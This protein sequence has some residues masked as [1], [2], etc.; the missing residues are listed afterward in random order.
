MKDITPKEA[1]SG[2]RPS[3]KHFMIF[4]SICHRHIPDERKRKLDDKSEALILIGYHPTGAYKLYDPV[5]KKVL[6][7]RD[8]VV[9]ESAT[10]DWNKPKPTSVQLQ[11]ECSDQVELLGQV[12]STQQQQRRS[13]RMRFHLSRLTDFKVFCS[14]SFVGEDEHVHMALLADVEP[15]VWQQAVQQDERKSAVL[16]ELNAIERNSTWELVEPPKTKKPI[17]VKWVFKLKRK[18]DGT[19]AKHKARLVARGF[20]QKEGVNYSKVYAPVARMETIRL[21]ITIASS[22]GWPMFQLHV[23]SA[24]LNGVLEEEVYVQQPPGFEMKGNEQQVAK[25]GIVW[26]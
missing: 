8:V 3:V 20:L 9:D 10:W 25:E 1:W 18:P 7:S 6:I 5:Q 26:P 22:K 19:I 2:C 21:A 17:D 4:G 24:F 11:L 15:L 13:Q 12:Q 16:E 14:D 23:K